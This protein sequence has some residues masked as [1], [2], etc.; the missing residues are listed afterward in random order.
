MLSP[1]FWMSFV[2]VALGIKWIADVLLSLASLELR[3]TRP[4]G[5]PVR[6]A[7]RMPKCENKK[8]A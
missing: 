2:V 5:E 3:K 6:P 1:L 8:A 4:V 7:R